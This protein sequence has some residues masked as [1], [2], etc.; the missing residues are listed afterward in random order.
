[1]ASPTPPNPGLSTYSFA[2]NLTHLVKIAEVYSTDAQ[3]IFYP[4]ANLWDSYVESDEARKFFIHLRKLL[5][6]LYTEITAFTNRYFESYIKGIY[7][8]LSIIIP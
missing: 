5:T 1:M 7:N 6:R 4:I 2:Y 8:N 3:C